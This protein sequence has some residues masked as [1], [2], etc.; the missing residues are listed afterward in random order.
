MKLE[1]N[2]NKIKSELILRDELPNLFVEL[3][4]K[5]G[6]EIGVY[7]GSFTEKFCKAGLKMYAIDPWVAYQGI[8]SEQAEQERQNFLY[9]HAVMILRDYNCQ[10]IRS[11]SIDA[12][13]YFKDGELDFV[14]IDANHDFKHFAEDIFEWNKK[15][16]KGGIVAG[17]DYFLSPPNSGQ[18]ICQISPVVDAYV[19]AM[20]IS[21]LYIIES[22]LTTFKDDGYST[23]YFYK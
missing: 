23:W 10:V 21:S 1:E 12:L 6:A 5:T 22:M 18:F 3:G 7:K 13:K 9:N 8:G 2:I 15:V 11:T 17:H 14:Y 20:G 4:Y 16:R 19:K